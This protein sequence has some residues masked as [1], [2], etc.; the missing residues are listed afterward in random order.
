M[1]K[2]HLA[3]I[4]PGYKHP[5]QASPDTVFAQL[6]VLFHKKRNSFN[7]FFFTKHRVISGSML[8]STKLHWRKANVIG[9]TYYFYLFLSNF[10]NLLYHPASLM[11]GN[12]FL[13]LQSTPKYTE[14]IHY[15]WYPHFLKQFLL[16]LTLCF[17]LDRA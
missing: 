11:Q 12:S 8:S 10:H 15:I 13:T 7:V 2:T 3:V 17:Y 9:L 4:Y 5:C 6:I 16:P 14:V 1:N